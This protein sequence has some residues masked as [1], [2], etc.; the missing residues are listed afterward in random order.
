M[1]C[2]AEDLAIERTVAVDPERGCC[3]GVL[4]TADWVLTARHGAPAS[5]CVYLGSDDGTLDR[6]RKAAIVDRYCL[7]GALPDSDLALLRVNFAVAVDLSWPNPV[8]G[9]FEQL[10]FWGFGQGSRRKFATQ[11]LTDPIKKLHAVRQIWGSSS[12]ASADRLIVT[13]SLSKGAV[14]GDSGGPLFGL[15]QGV[16]HLLGV[17]AAGDE[18]GTEIFSSYSA[19]YSWI[20]Q[21]VTDG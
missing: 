1:A 5:G 21:I 17:L 7:Q 6:D 16:W 13:D 3:S 19:N 11:Q 15:R 8:E 14:R 9:S 4:L 12:P 18:S 20:K 2:T 10:M